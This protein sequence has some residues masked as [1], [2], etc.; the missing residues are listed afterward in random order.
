MR[1]WASFL[2]LLVCGGPDTARESAEETLVQVW[3]F[4]HNSHL[5]NFFQAGGGVGGERLSRSL[6]RAGRAAD[7][8]RPLE[9]ISSLPPPSQ[10][11]PYYLHNQEA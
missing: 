10:L 6:Q 5:C 3:Q 8:H 2:L 11:S 9:G 4:G 7:T 1:I